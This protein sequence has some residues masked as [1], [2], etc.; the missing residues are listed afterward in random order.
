MISV[1][2]KFFPKIVSAERSQ[3]SV[4]VLQN[5]SESKNQQLRK[6]E[7][8]IAHPFLPYHTNGSAVCLSFLVEL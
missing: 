7:S 2:V 5:L 3:T 4:W 6:N 1:V 8:L